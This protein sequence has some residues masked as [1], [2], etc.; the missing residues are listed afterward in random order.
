MN[1]YQYKNNSW[2]EISV[3]VM[4]TN[5]P[6]FD[7]TLETISFAFISNTDE[8]PYK[9]MTK[10]KMVDE[11]EKALIFV[12]TSDSVN[13]HSLNPLRY[14]HH[15]VATQNTRELSKHIVRNSVFSQPANPIKKSFF[16]ITMEAHNLRN[17]MIRT[18]YSN[19][20]PTPAILSPNEKV[21]KAFVKVNVF[22]AN[23][24]VSQNDPS[25][26]NT[27]SKLI[28]LSN[29]NT[30]DDINDSIDTGH[31]EFKEDEVYFGLAINQSPARIPAQDGQITAN[32]VGGKWIFNTQLECPKLKERINDARSLNPNA[33]VLVSMFPSTDLSNNWNLPITQETMGSAGANIVR[34]VFLVIQYEIILETYYYTAYDILNLLIERQKQETD[35]YTNQPLFSLPTRAENAELYDLLTNAIAPNFTFTQLTMYE[36]VAEVFRLFDS[37]FTMNE[38][39]VLGIEYLNDN[40]GTAITPTL[41][42]KNMSIAEE[43]YTNKLVSYYQD[44]RKIVDFPNRKN[45][46][47]KMSSEGFGVIQDGDHNL[48]VN[49]PIDS[50]KQFI[51]TASDLT[52]KIEETSY[53]I[54]VSGYFPIDI[55]YYLVDFQL[56]TLL[57]SSSGI[58]DDPRILNQATTVYFEKGTPL[59][60]MGLYNKTEYD[61][62]V[63]TIDDCIKQ[64]FLRFLGFY[65][66]QDRIELARYDDWLDYNFHLT[67]YA[68]LDGRAS[69]ETI[70]NKYDGE[71]IIDQVNGAVDL[72][73]MGVNM[74][75]ISL[76]LGEPTLSATH[77]ITKDEDKIKVGD[78]YT[79]NNDKWIV[80][81]A[82]YQY[83]SSDVLQGQITLIK[84]YNALSLRTRVLRE[85]RMSNI[86]SALTLKSEDNYCEY[87]YF[88]SDD[89]L[90]DE[91]AEPISLSNEAIYMSLYQSIINDN[92]YNFEFGK[93][94]VKN[95][96]AY[97]YDATSFQNNYDAD[98]QV[99]ERNIAMPL[100]T[101]GFGN[102]VC[103]EMTFNEPMNGGNKTLNISSGWW[104]THTTWLSQPVYYS[105]IGGLVDEFKIVGIQRQ[106][107][108][109]NFIDTTDFNSQNYP[110]INV[111][112]S[113]LALKI[114]G[115]KVYKQPNEVFSL[116]YQLTFL[117]FNQYNDF[118]GSQFINN[119]FFSTNTKIQEDLYIYMS[120][121]NFKYSILDTEG[122]ADSSSTIKKITGATIT[123]SSG[124]ITLT[125]QHETF[126]NTPKSWAICDSR[127]KILFASNKSSGNYS[128][129]VLYFLP[130]HE[131]LD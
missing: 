103:F 76:K 88:S 115:Y 26:Y 43:R 42:A 70:N 117:P 39:N 37:I 49:Y 89:D 105:G 73:K 15:I 109:D 100:T 128:T 52:M 116:N 71:S 77:T 124:K 107:I 95:E 108:K 24:D 78:I 16:S 14:K 127:G 87:L 113:L 63:L 110:Q 64:G 68:S 56:W 21:S 66:G 131:R 19:C 84:N 1:I 81:V 69:I 20:Q 58:P 99:E 11:T 18:K 126:G 3:E 62:D 47:A 7:E 74:L 111:N 98:L 79:Y 55:T 121:S 51:T 36:C 122:H 65:Q 50:I 130:R 57:D 30:F 60:R 86:S 25:S 32:D 104:F 106:E 9:P 28:P 4:P 23:T 102:S 2:V 94:F 6:T 112:T 101:Y 75:G 114:D 93:A 83:L 8:Q 46:F 120:M 96:K 123:N 59:V 41:S 91:T 54:F 85:K 45:E 22:F 119:S 92:E 97:K 67:Y 80:N 129:K 44:A 82:N 38:N 34:P 5:T 35:N 10:F 27:A 29:D 48:K 13:L 53:T 90:L 31:I 40:N 72:N 33:N 17:S 61:Y 125:I 118:V 12:L